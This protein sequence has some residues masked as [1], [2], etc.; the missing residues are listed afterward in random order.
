MMNSVYFKGFFSICP[1]GV[2][3]GGTKFGTRLD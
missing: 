1:K 2:F 3:D